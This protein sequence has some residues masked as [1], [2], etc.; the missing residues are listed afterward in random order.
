[1]SP[2]LWLAARE[3]AARGRRVALAAAVVGA[4]AASVTATEL[5]ARAR[6]AAVAEQ[7]DAMGPAVTVVPRGTTPGGLARYEL[8]GTLPASTEALVRRAL[9][10]RLRAVERRAVFH[11]HVAGARRL[12]VG[13]DAFPDRVRGGPS[14]A[15]VGSVLGRAL[16][17]G[18]TVTIDDRAFEVARIL[19]S[20]GSVEDVALFI[21]IAQAGA[22]TVNE[23]RVFLSSGTSPREAERLLS[24]AAPGLAVVRSDRGDVADGSLP[25][26]L[27]RHR[28]VAY[29]VMAAVAALTLLIAAHLDA[30]ERKVELATLIAIGASRFT[31]VGGVL[32][33][34]AI[35]A[36]AG[37]LAGAVAG[38]AV[39]A[40]LEPALRGL[41][42]SVIETAGGV[43]VAGVVLGAAA[44][45]PSALACVVRDPVRDL[46]EG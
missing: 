3:L 18:S 35:V 14:A 37:A 17:V 26:A 42:A 10:S 38:G 22:V 23:L 39:A 29:A 33:R 43:V 34:S 19:P 45:G 24:Q 4:I 44:A 7:V 41:A 40:L 27:A 12:V 16:P 15:I 9:G 11:R 25:E 6:E 46:Q 5:V 31:V 13:V 20:A 32:V 28:A 2:A 21:P 30:T 8:Q 1:M 36:A